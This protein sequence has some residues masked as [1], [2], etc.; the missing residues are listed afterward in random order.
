MSVTAAA[1]RLGVSRVQL[2][3]LLNGHAAM[4]AEM[5][6]RVSLLTGTSAESWLMNQVQWDLWRISNEPPPKLEPM[7]ATP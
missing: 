6:L 7:V 5:A 1:K 2:S 4:T 3:R